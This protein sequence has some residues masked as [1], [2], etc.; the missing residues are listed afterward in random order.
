[1]KNNFIDKIDL[2][3]LIVSTFILSIMLFY[4]VSSDISA[5]IQGGMILNNGGS[6]YVDFFDV[7]P[8]FVYYFFEFLYSIFGKDIFLYRLFDVIYQIIFLISSIYIFKKLSIE[9][10]YIR[11]YLILMPLSYVILNNFNVFQMESLLFLPLLWYFYFT[12]LSSRDKRLRNFIIKGLILGVMINLKYTFGFLI[13]ADII[14]SYHR[15]IKIKLISLRILNQVLIAFLF[16]LICFTPILIKGHF[17]EFFSFMDYMKVYSS[18]PPYSID[19]FITMLKVVLKFFTDSYSIILLL[20]SILAIFILEKKDFKYSLGK[21]K[22]GEILLYIIILFITVVIERKM[23]SY[24]EQRIYP[25]LLILASVGFVFLYERIIKLNY[26]T[27]ISIAIIS[28]IFSPLPRFVNLLRLPYYKVMDEEDKYYKFFV[29]GE[30]GNI[31]YKHHTLAKYVNSNFD[32]DKILLVD[33][34]GNEL[35][36][37]MDKDTKYAFPQSAFYLN[38]LSP[39]KLINRAYDDFEDAEIIIVQDNDKS[40]IMFYNGETSLSALKQRQKFWNY[41]TNNFKQDTVIVGDFLI[42]KRISR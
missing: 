14:I 40:S 38:E 41:I 16:T 35:V 3:F 24:H 8:P 31:L 1:M 39:Q 19:Y 11:T 2:Y 25:I 17:G 34:G 37:F 30:N 23:L 22:V 20:C 9:S 29:D 26:P 15:D 7:K 6:L 13:L 18:N 33:T 4:S 32:T 27:I 10:K 42:F 5:F 21:L 12:I 36:V 28:I